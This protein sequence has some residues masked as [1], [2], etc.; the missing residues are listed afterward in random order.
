MLACVLYEANDSTGFRVV[1]EQPHVRGHGE[2]TERGGRF[3]EE[4]W[5][6]SLQVVMG[7]RTYL[8]FIIFFKD[9]F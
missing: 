1:L 7:S 9:I 2:E 5:L 6:K 4:D 8:F 3:E